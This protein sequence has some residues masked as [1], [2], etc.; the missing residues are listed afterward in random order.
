MF[1]GPMARSV[2]SNFWTSEDVTRYFDQV[3]PAIREFCE[4][5]G[6]DPVEVSMDAVVVVAKK[7]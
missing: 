6:L 7:P 2:I 3:G 4:K 1:G 5:Q